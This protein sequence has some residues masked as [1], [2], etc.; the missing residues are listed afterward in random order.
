MNNR[1]LVLAFKTLLAETIKWALSPPTTPGP[2]ALRVI[3][4]QTTFP[5]GTPM[6]KNTT[7]ITLPAVADGNPEG[8]VTRRFTVLSGTETVLS[9]EYTLQPDTV[10]VDP[11]TVNLAQGVEATLSLVDV[12]Q[13]GNASAPD[14]FTFTPTDVTAPSTPGKFGIEVTGEVNE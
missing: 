3:G 1:K 14:V 11:V 13:A 10:N 5:K 9:A 2:F 4:E 7:V 6:K 8:V 12:D